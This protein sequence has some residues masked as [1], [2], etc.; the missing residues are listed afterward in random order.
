MHP[1][2]RDRITE[3]EFDK[4]KV[5]DKIQIVKRFLIPRICANI[6][7]R[8]EQ[9]HIPENTIEQL[10]R[11]YCPSEAGVRDIKKVME[12]I[13]K[14]LNLLQLP[15]ELNIP[16]GQVRPRRV[17]DKM[18]I[19]TPIAEKLLID[20]KSGNELPMSVQMFYT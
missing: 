15:Q 20:Y 12:A 9:F 11:R 6:G 4:F 5:L 19:T 18:V 14:R 16:Y 7:L 3:I 8:A 1:I 2:L 13:F 17:E 10:I